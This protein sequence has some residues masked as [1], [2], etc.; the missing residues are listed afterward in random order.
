MSAPN[1]PTDRGLVWALLLDGSGRGR[2][3]GWDGIGAWRPEQG[4]LWAHFDISDPGPDSWLEEKAGLEPPIAAALLAEDTRPRSAPSRN[5]LLV[6]LRGVNLNPGAEPDDMV[7]IRVWLEKNRIFS[8]RRRRLQTSSE[9]RHLIEAGE[10]PRTSGEFLCALVEKLVD[11]IGEAVDDLDGQIDAL[12]EGAGA[13]DV[14]EL[15]YQLSEL[16]RQT[17]HLRR[18]L[19]PQRDALDRLV[20]QP[21]PVLSERDNLDIREQ[22]DRVQRFIEDLDL[23]RERGMVSQEEFLSRIAHQQNQRVLV[24]SVVSAIFLPLTFLTGLMGMNVGGLPGAGSRFGFAGVVLLIAALAACAVWYF[25]RRRW[26]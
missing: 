16:R 21:D 14:M 15:R 4:L 18:F 5:G 10:G 22:A 7:S 25:R 19:A 12:E 13:G 2:Q 9:I 24:L 1:P 8:T 20:R 17:A 6:I 26:L 3:V 11:R 23:I